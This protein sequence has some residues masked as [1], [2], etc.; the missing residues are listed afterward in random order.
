MLVDKKFNLCDETSRDD[1]NTRF[2]DKVDWDV[3][4]Q[5]LS[6]NPVV[7]NPKHTKQFSFVPT[8]KVILSANKI[9]K[10][11]P[12]DNAIKRRLL[13]IN[14]PNS[15]EGREDKELMDKLSK[16]KSGILNLFLRHGKQAIKENYSLNIPDSVKYMA[17]DVA[18]ELSSDE[19]FF[20]EYLDFEG[21]EWV[22]MHD[23]YTA[24]TMFCSN[25]GISGMYVKANNSVG[26]YLT[27]YMRENNIDMDR[28]KRT[29]KGY[30][31]RLSLK[32]VMP[33]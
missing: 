6:G 7:S 29:G 30:E 25:Q 2:G 14:F 22:G 20:K 8:A 24:Y 5:V 11:I 28:K 10:H 19:L 31:Y 26:R 16:E 23:I 1:R 3:L 27:M 15:F 4:K 32:S 12:D 18:S 13:M 17:D 21:T 9:P 33:Y